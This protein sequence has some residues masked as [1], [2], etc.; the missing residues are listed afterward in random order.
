MKKRAFYP[1]AADRPV[2]CHPYAKSTC[3][4]NALVQVI[5]ML[6][7][8]SEFIALNLYK[9]HRRILLEVFVSE[10][11]Y[12]ERGLKGSLLANDTEHAKEIPHQNNLLL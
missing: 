2:I 7:K 12:F 8:E 9:I 10:S 6:Y 3:I 4:F 1:P 11:G 5:Y